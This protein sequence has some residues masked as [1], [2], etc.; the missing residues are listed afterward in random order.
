[1]AADLIDRKGPPIIVT[2]MY[3][4][5]ILLVIKFLKL[6]ILFNALANDHLA[7]SSN[8]NNEYVLVDST[9]IENH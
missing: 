4:I 3:R 6:E 1:M 5:I 2:M 9:E 8:H 7:L